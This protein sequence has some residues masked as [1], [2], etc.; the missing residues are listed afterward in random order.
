MLATLWIGIAAV[1]L[2]IGVAIGWG[3]ARSRNA[4]ELVSRAEKAERAL[5]EEMSRAQ[6]AIAAA[7][8]QARRDIAALQAD[9]TALVE[10]LNAEHRTES[11]KLAKHLSDA[12]DELDKLRVKVSA[13]AGQPHTDT[14]YG[15]PATMPLGDL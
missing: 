6:A 7:E 2:M 14:G 4:A 10:R 11:E 9:S 15:F 8:A 3:M 12:Y 1:A 13:A 5:K